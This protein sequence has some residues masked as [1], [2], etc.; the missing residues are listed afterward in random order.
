MISQ[1]ATMQFALPPLEYFNNLQSPETRQTMTLPFIAASKI[2]DG[3]PIL[4][5][6]DNAIV[7]LKSNLDINFY[8]GFEF[9]F[10]AC[11]TCRYSGFFWFKFDL[12]SILTEEE[13]NLKNNK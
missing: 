8:T 12:R 1:Q 5:I 13:Y 10:K 6:Y 11:G 9:R 2:F 4:N 7:T 3:E